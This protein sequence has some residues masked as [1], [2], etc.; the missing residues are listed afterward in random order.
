MPDCSRFHSEVKRRIII[1]VV[2]VAA[3]TLSL[4]LM[5]CLGVGRSGSDAPLVFAAASLA[6]VAEELAAAYRDHS[7]NTVRFTFGGSN[8]AVSQIIEGGAPADAVWFAGWTP[9]ARLLDAK[10]VAEQDVVEVCYNK[11]VVVTGGRDSGVRLSS[12]GDLVGAGTVAIPDPRTS[13]A[14]EYARAALQ[15]AGVWTDLS[16]QIVPTLDVRFALAAA[17]S[18]NADFAIV[19]ETDARTEDVTV[20]LEPGTLGD[21]RPL[22]YAANVSDNPI[23]AD[24]VEYLL[25]A[26]AKAILEAHGFPP[27]DGAPE[28]GR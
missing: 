13:P 7:G 6:D 22:Y 24:F 28:L 27:V 10:R 21:V 26:P 25:S 8:Q 14:G 23:A 20:L 5:S 2:M 3:L 9:M 12:L 18:G 17:A 4:P 1:A 11:T 19:Y 15:R 16:G